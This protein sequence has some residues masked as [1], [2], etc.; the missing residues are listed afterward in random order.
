LNFN[1]FLPGF[2]TGIGVVFALSLY[3][4]HG[5][6]QVAP[7]ASEVRQADSSLVLAVTDSTPSR[8][9]VH[10]LPKG[11]KEERRV[12]VV[13]KPARGLVVPTKPEETMHVDTNAH[14]KPAILEHDSCDCPPVQVDLSLVRIPDRTQRVIASSP[15]G[16]VLSGID[17]PLVPVAP[18]V[19]NRYR[20]VGVVLGTDR[21]IGVFAE[22]DVWRFRIGGSVET[23]ANGLQSS[24]RLGWIF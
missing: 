7:K 11:A 24:T 18:L 19:R 8:P 3:K 10:I 20:A 2:L 9:P 17:I 22:V 14:T 6:P 23:G 13:V 12:S 16:Y 15:D 5:P 4:G 1:R 21:A